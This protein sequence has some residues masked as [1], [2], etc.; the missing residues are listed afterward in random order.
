MHLSFYRLSADPFRLSPDPRFCFPHR[1]YRRAMIYMRHALERAEGFIIITGQPGMGKTTLI[2]DLLQGLNTGQVRVARL[3]STQLAADDLLRLVAYAFELNPEHMDKATLLNRIA[4]FLEQQHH[5]GR[6]SLL[7]VDEAQDV[8]EEAL[9]ELRLLTNMQVMGHQLLQIFLVGQQELRDVVSAPS[10]EQLHQRVIAATYLEPLNVT[11]T[12]EYIKHR[13]R[14]VGWSGRPMISNQTYAMIH[15]F[16]HGIPRQIN[17]ICSRLLLHGSIEEQDRLGLQDLKIVIEELHGEMLLPLGMQ[18]IA[19][20]IVWPEPVTQESYDELP[21]P[22][23]AP[24][25]P[26]ATAQPDIGTRVPTASDQPADR[27]AAPP[28]SQT[29]ALEADGQPAAVPP[30]PSPAPPA[31]AANDPPEPRDPH[32]SQTTHALRQ[33]PQPPKRSPGRV[34]GLTVLLAGL[35]L[36]LLYVTGTGSDR[37]TDHRLL[38]WVNP[39]LEALR[40][41]L[42]PLMENDA[43][44]TDPRADRPAAAPL[45]PPEVTEQDA[46][47]MLASAMPPPPEEALPEAVPPQESIQEAGA[48]EEATVEPA[49]MLPLT[50]VQQS[51]TQNGLLVERIDETTLKVNLSSDGMFDFGSALI[52]PEATPALQKLSDVMNRHE[53]TLARVVGHT[54]S[55]GAADYNLYLSERRAS[56][57]ADY[58]TGLGLPWERIQSEGRGDRDTR[59]EEASADQPQQRRRV[60]IYLSP[61]QE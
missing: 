61:V 14:R 46:P 52:K 20:N 58:L 12:K 22:A 40:S 59:L 15:Q 27:P 4:R 45:P 56:A 29:E 43:L 13:L 7:I 19:D 51:L 33:A 17:Q 35:G 28:D 32:R 10:L 38:S 2:N 49:P 5:G 31:V 11:E 26:P 50:D 18:E 47:D 8:T 16:S 54:D 44:A 41:H 34:L 53:R 21:R 9:E 60:E 6:R 37:L 57:V 55:S 24:E 42:S 25:P 36:A 39:G 1:T 23:P 3:V 48:I 30:A